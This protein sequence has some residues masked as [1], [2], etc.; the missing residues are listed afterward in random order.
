MRPQFDLQVRS[1]LYFF[2]L[3]VPVVNK[4]WKE[5]YVCEN[6]NTLAKKSVTTYVMINYFV[7]FMQIVYDDFLVTNSSLRDVH[8]SPIIQVVDESVTITCHSHIM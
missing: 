8:G 3:F 7:W 5:N 4:K 6:D 1:Q 2:W